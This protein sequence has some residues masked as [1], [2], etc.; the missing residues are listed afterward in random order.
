MFETLNTSIVLCE[1]ED[2][3]YFFI[4]ILILDDQITM[5]VFASKGTLSAQNEAYMWVLD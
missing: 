5:Y 4:L 2:F 3:F 1:R